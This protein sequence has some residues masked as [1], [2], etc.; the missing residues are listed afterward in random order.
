M[1]S[2]TICPKSGLIDL[3]TRQKTG[4]KI[5]PFSLQSAQTGDAIT[6]EGGRL[7]LLA[8]LVN[9]RLQG[10]RE[11][12]EKIPDIQS[13]K[14]WPMISVLMP[15]WNP[16]PEFLLQAINSVRTQKYSNWQFCIADDASTNPD[17]TEILRSLAASDKR[18]SITFREE[19]G[20]ICKASNSALE[21]V[22]A[23]YIAFLDH[24]DM[25]APGSFGHC[26]RSNCQKPFIAVHLY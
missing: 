25:L 2:R 16:K 20:H 3:K 10:L 21:L 6:A 13:G 17:I 18:V 8:G 9:L 5:Q 11:T 15:V 14:N 1:K 22:K 19:N 7:Q 23:P 12:G 26:S 4:V 24:D